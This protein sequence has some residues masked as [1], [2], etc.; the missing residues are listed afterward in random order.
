MQLDIAYLDLNAERSE[1]EGHQL[2]VASSPLA[3]P[4][5]VRHVYTQLSL[6]LLT[7]LLSPSSFAGGSGVALM[8]GRLFR[9]CVLEQDR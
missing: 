7:L 8:A 6:A 3:S 4:E 9:L 2:L 5:W 1:V